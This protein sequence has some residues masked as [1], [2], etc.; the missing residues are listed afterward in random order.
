M[1]AIALLSAFAIVATVA[2]H[3]LSEAAPAQDEEPR[4]V[5]VKF[6]DAVGAGSYLSDEEVTASLRDLEGT[7]VASLRLDIATRELESDIGGKTEKG[8]LE[9][10]D[11]FTLEKTVRAL[12]A[13]WQMS[14]SGGQPMTAGP[15]TGGSQ[16]VAACI[17]HCDSFTCTVICFYVSLPSPE[18]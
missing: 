1:R 18:P 2:P 16:Q 3:R 8:Q 6:E 5:E 9:S 11:G 12:Y 7:E 13:G 17:N 14:E 4:A 10:L 15:S